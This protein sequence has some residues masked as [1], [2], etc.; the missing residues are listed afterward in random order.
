[1]LS[2]TIAR[3]RGLLLAG[4]L[5]VCAADITHAADWRMDPA[6]S[7]LEYTATLQKT[8]VS[9]TFKEFDVRG[10]FDENRLADSRVDV[11]VVVAS[12]DMIDAEVNMAIRGP[13]WFDSARFPRAVF[14]TSDILRTGENRYLAR[15][16]V[17]VKGVEQQI[18]VPF[19]WTNEA[20]TATI[21]GELT[22]RRAAF[23]IGVGEWTSTEVV[24]PDV[25]VKFS[26][27]LRRMD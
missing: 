8:R 17:T 22:V 14:H 1:M 27:K 16:V 15:G 6:G 5:L 24:G 20:D 26:V 13:D 7:K 3:V 18:E 11:A 12:V 21:A 10:R 23:H 19:V 25:T 9:G 4:L 2:R